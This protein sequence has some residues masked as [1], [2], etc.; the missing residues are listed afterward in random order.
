MW[1]DTYPIVSDIA[2]A[3]GTSGTLV[4]N[5]DYIA[6][7]AFTLALGDIPVEGFN[8]QVICIPTVSGSARYNQAWAANGNISSYIDE[9]EVQ[10]GNVS[11]LSV[12]MSTP[13]EWEIQLTRITGVVVVMSEVG[14]ICRVALGSDA[15]D[16][17]EHICVPV[18]TAT[19]VDG[20]VTP[21]PFAV[22]SE[23]VSTPA[24][25]DDVH[26]SVVCFN[27]SAHLSSISGNFEVGPYGFDFSYGSGLG[28]DPDLISGFLTASTSH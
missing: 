12:S 20:V 13:T 11:G 23:Q 14:L 1:Y 17:L 16:L 28:E 5:R 9:S 22:T 25:G 26:G 8:L 10:Y 18:A 24:L 27:Y 7:S 2:P 3:V 19:V 21:S 4:G 15:A 6:E